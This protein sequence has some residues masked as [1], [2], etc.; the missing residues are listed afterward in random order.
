MKFLFVIICFVMS[1]PYACAQNY[2]N[3]LDIFNQYQTYANTY[4]SR[5]LELYSPN[6]KIIREVIKPNGEKVRIN[7]PPK[8][9]FNELKIG[10]KTARL[11]KYKN[12]YK[13]ITVQEIPNGIKITAVRQPVNE[14]YWL[15]MYQILESTDSGY[16]ITEEMMQTKVQAFLKAK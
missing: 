15:Q 9:F 6:V 5:L 8:R 13:D 14:N 3:G 10:Q 1:L 12:K 4:D 11:K 16:K 2:I 7:I